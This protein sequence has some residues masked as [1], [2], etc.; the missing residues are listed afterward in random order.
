[1]KESALYSQYV[2]G[3][4]PQEMTPAQILDSV[5]EKPSDVRGGEET[6][7]DEVVDPVLKPLDIDPGKLDEYI[8]L[9]CSSRKRMSLA[10]AGTYTRV[11]VL[12]SLI[13]SLWQK[14]HFRLGDLSLKASWEWN[15]EPVGAA[16]AFYESVQYAADYMDSLGIKFSSYTFRNS[17]ELSLTFTPVLSRDTEDADE[18]FVK[19]AFR[20]EHPVL[21]KGRMCPG[22]LVADPQSWVVYVPFETCDFRLGGS[23]LAQTL[24][25]GGG[26]VPQIADADYFLDCFEVL[27]ELVEDGIVISG[28]TVSEGGM[29]KTLKSMAPE[30]L[31]VDVDLSGIVNAYEE[32]NVVRILFSEVPGA[33][34]QIR[35]IDFD[36]LDAELLLQD[37]AYFPLGHPVPGGTINVKASAKSGIQT[38]LESLMRNAEGED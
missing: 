24:G 4:V 9:V 18:I 29:I 3:G 32:P 6:I 33:I 19:Q 1:M 25:L 20:S 12:S 5:C 16:A 22:T 15:M 27:R 10:F 23:L 30:G 8:S 17:P 11:K 38:I 26:V 35:D 28:A 13:G 7:I 36:Y 37:V 2:I 34:I 14:G 31:G 21:S